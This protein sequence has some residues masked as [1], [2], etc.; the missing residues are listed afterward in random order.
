MF[1]ALQIAATGMQA[2]Q[3]HVDAIA[4]NLANVNTPG[5]KKSRV[6]FVDLVT[7]AAASSTR[8]GTEDAVATLVAQRTG[9]GVGIASI[10][11][12]FDL[13]DLR[14]T[15]SA[16]DVAI[17]GDGFLEITMADGSRAWSRGGT[18]KVSPD[19]TLATQSGHA[20]KPSITVPTDTQTLTIAADGKV[21]AASAA[22]P[23]PVDLGQLQM[24]RFMSPQTLT[25]MG[26]GLY[27]AG[28]GSGEP[29]GGRAG[30][31]AM[32]ALRQGYL[33]G[34]N[35][36]LVDEM[37]NLMVAQ[38]AYEASVKVVQASDDMLGMINSLRR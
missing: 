12:M 11:K 22:R 32:G 17:A 19:G 9:S 33:E 6:A 13:G 15:E 29:I 34:S 5:Y 18:L 25:A 26:D 1:D 21:H 36:K 2:Q 24:V 7:Q 4:N 31:D 37:V 16:M 27:R 35:V 8:A 38:R 3:M 20:L 14:K 28:E 30:E 10:G 23:T